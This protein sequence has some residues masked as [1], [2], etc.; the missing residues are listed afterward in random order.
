MGDVAESPLYI[1][2]GSGS[3]EELLLSPQHM[4]HG[5]NLWS[6]SILLLMEKVIF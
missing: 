5:L 2:L 3:L 6:I 4:I 1:T